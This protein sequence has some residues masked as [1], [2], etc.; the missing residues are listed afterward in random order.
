MVTGKVAQR[1]LNEH[2]KTYGSYNDNP[3]LN[4]IVCDAEFPDGQVKEYGT[5]ILVETMLTQVDS[6]GHSL[7]FKDAIIDH[8]ANPK[9]ADT[10]EEK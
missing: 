3:F 6:D 1:S 10:N 9:V 5:N 2:G 8:C 4:S 7:T